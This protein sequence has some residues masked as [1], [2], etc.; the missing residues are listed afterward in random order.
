MQCH[1]GPRLT[2]DAFHVTRLA[3]G[4][5]DGSVD[6]GRSEGIAELRASE[7]VG[8]GRWSDAPAKGRV[9]S[10]SEGAPPR[11]LLG[12]F[13]TPSLRGIAAAAP[14]GHGGTEASLVSVTE[15]YGMGGVPAS[16]AR[17]A[18][19]LE[20]WLMRFDVTAQWAIPPF[21]A[22]LTAEPIVP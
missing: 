15:S 16:D 6:P 13:K 5:A 4:R 12:A 17:V 22:T 19:D 10:A 7:F 20:P 8:I 3:S 11:A 1:W 18:G 21:L 9:L 14:Y 2:D